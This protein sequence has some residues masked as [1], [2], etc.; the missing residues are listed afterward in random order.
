MDA[1]H[2]CSWC[3]KPV[4]GSN[5]F[6][7]PGCFDASHWAAKKLAILEHELRQIEAELAK[8]DTGIK[9]FDEIAHQAKRLQNAGCSVTL[10]TLKRDRLLMATKAQ[11]LN[12]DV[13]GL[14]EWFRTP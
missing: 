14:L 12:Q 11:R 1:D 5:P 3:R 2:G 6:C 7:G 9:E 13:E 8:L 10:E 4:E